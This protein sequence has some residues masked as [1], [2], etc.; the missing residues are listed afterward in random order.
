MQNGGGIKKIM[1][2]Y[3]VIFILFSF[4]G[5]VWES[6]YCTVCEKKWA[7]RGFLYGPVCP[8]YGF[9]C[10][11]ALAGF[12]LSSSGL[13]PVLSAWQIF[14]LGFAVSMILEYP[15]SFVLEKLFH[16]RWWDYS[17]I[18]LNIKGRTSV[19]TS[20]AFGLAS[21]AVMRYAIPFIS[22]LI[23]V[24][25][26]WLLTLT[27]LVLTALIS[28]DITLTASALTDF[29]KEIERLDNSFQ[30]YM[31]DAVYQML[32]AQKGFRAKTVKRIAVFKFPKN[33]VKA[34]KK[35]R[36]ELSEHSRK[37]KEFER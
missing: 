18:P 20:L 23:A 32:D 28:V 2:R 31:T 21:I 26:E 10:S 36:Q 7:N 30:S 6:I 1:C 29:Q 9:G 16:A 12:D 14:I 25:P 19:P 13:I 3:I 34:L 27:A 8:I 5:W 22:S 35:E 24:L 37:S 11:I 33:I 4:F 15:T 17:N